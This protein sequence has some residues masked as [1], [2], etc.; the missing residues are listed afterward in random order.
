MKDAVVLNQEETIAQITISNP[1]V[2]AL[3]HEVR[4]GLMKAIQ[5][6][7]EDPQIEA[8]AIIGSGKFFSA[9]ADIQEFKKPS[10]RPQLP[11]ICNLIESSTKPVFALIDLR[12]LSAQFPPRLIPVR[13]RPLPHFAL[14]HGS[15]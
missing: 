13:L 14:H 1:P 12:R 3:S 9:G 11:E 8:L 2:N 7:L 10:R 5:E 15:R 4:K 6:S